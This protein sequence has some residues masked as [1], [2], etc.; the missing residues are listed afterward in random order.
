M[1]GQHNPQDLDALDADVQRHVERDW[2]EVVAWVKR[3]AVVYQ[4]EPGSPLFLDDRTRAS[5]SPGWCRQQH[6]DVLVSQLAR[7]SLATGS[8]HLM[9]TVRYLAQFGPTV[10]T[11]HSMLRTAIWG[12]AQGVWLLAPTKR[13]DRVE[14]ATRVLYYSKINSLKWLDTFDEAD[15]ATD[16]VDQLRRA[17]QATRD[18]LGRLGQQRKIDQ[19]QVVKF[20]SGLVFPGQPGAVIECE[21]SWRTLGAVAH[22][23]PWE[24]E[25][26]VTAERA[27][28]SPPGTATAVFRARWAELGGELSYATGFLRK[29]WALLDQASKCE[30]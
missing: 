20:V 12:A 3:V 30:N 24:L 16:D 23:L 26:R 18:V 29:G 27:S 14:R 17:K 9:S 7:V 15:P 25:T 6:R 1:T 4:P 8:Q 19:T 10:N 28:A 11:M 22:G 2:P 13:A 5:R 21:R